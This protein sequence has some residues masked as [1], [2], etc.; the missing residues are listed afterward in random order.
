MPSN[1]SVNG[2]FLPGAI[3]KKCFNIA[4][5]RFFLMFLILQHVNLVTENFEV[6]RMTLYFKIDYEG[7][8]WFLFA[9]SL[10]KINKDE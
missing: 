7:K 4:K 10:K 2:R 5:V 8:I 9:T 6:G 3:E 1:F